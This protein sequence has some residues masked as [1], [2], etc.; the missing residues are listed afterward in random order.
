MFCDEHAIAVVALSTKW[1]LRAVNAITAIKVFSQVLLAPVFFLKIADHLRLT[2]SVVAAGLAVLLGLTRISE[3]FANFADPWAGSTYNGNALATALIKTHFAYVGWH[4]AFNV[5]AEVRSPDPVRTVKRAGTIA[6]GL[7][8]ALFV[9][10][11]VAYIAA[12]PKA[13]M[14]EAGQLVGALF[15]QK[16]FGASWAAKIL[17]VMVVCSCLGNIVSSVDIVHVFSQKLSD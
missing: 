12:I 9:L 14:R 17:P 4:N 8:T 7:V 5:L 13:E 6:L 16:V 1:S 10:T 15:F 3:P 2:I 11:N